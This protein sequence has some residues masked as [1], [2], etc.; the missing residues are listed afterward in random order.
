MYMGAVGS[1]YPEVSDFGSIQGELV[2]KDLLKRKKERK[3]KEK[4]PK[5][6]ERVKLSG[7]TDY[8]QLIKWLTEH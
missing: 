8:G 4:T 5:D 2:D 7:K 3:K 6:G 1:L